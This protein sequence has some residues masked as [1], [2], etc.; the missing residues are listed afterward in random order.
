M[1]NGT[2]QNSS[3]ALS[4]KASK[5]FSI[6]HHSLSFLLYFNAIDDV[7]SNNK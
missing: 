2:K 3:F 6:D 4:L 5:N 1:I 7:L